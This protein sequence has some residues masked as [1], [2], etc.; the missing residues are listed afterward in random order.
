[1]PKE[2]GLWENI[3]NFFKNLF[4][5]KYEIPQDKDEFLSTKTKRKD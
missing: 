2:P 4:K 5:P 3:I 1:V